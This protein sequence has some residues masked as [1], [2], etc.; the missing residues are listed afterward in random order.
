MTTLRT[1]TTSTSRFIMSL[2]ATWSWDKSYLNYAILTCAS[3]R[4][5]GHDGLIFVIR[6]W[7]TVRSTTRISISRD[8]PEPRYWTHF[9]MQPK[10]VVKWISIT[11]LARDIFS[12]RPSSASLQ[13]SR[14]L[15]SARFS[16]TDLAECQYLVSDPLSFCIHCNIWPRQYQGIKENYS[17]WTSSCV[18]FDVIFLLKRLFI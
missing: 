6:L 5:W 11:I 13:W 10:T 12:S 2:T 1:Y 14:H 9:S 16:W 18:L 8:F 7:E 3:L 4:T 17:L 15:F